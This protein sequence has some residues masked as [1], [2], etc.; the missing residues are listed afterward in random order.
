MQVEM[1]KRWIWVIHL[2]FIMMAWR[3]EAQELVVLDWDRVLKKA[4]AE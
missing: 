2:V 3:V 4:R 1:I